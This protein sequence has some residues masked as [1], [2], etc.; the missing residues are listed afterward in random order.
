MRFGKLV[1]VAI[2]LA[3]FMVAALPMVAEASTPT[4]SAP[5]GSL[6]SITYYTAKTHFTISDSQWRSFFVSVY[7]NK[8]Y[9]SYNWANNT[10]QFL[11]LFDLGY[12][13]VNPYGLQVL[14][15]LAGIG[16]PSIKNFTIAFN[17]T[18]HLSSQVSGYSNIAALN[19]GAYPG[20][21]WSVPKIKST[22]TTYLETGIIVAIFAST[23]VLYF[24]FNRKK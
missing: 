17:L 19:A 8:S 13:S 16:F 20:F 7:D 6:P 4:L 22:T 1:P 9:V 10:T 24:I 11:I 12:K 3:L 21:S 23:F 18:K 2:I 14:N 15:A 5:S